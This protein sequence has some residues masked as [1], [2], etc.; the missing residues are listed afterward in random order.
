M[1]SGNS[2]AADAN[3]THASAIPRGEH[4]ERPKPARVGVPY[5]THTIAAITDQY[6]ASIASGLI[7][8]RP[9]VNEQ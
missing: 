5:T 8:R 4:S 1:R 9:A 3:S 6:E 2:G 7:V